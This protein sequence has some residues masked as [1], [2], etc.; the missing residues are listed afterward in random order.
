MEQRS[1][2]ETCGVLPSGLF[3]LRCWMVVLKGV[4]ST[5]ADSE[6]VSLRHDLLGVWIIVL[7]DEL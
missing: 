4:I 7:N 6:S 5:G 1:L 3:F 2:K